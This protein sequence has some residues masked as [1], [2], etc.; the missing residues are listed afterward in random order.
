MRKIKIGEF[1]AVFN[2]M[3]E[4]FP[5]DEYRDKSAQRAL[6]DRSRYALY[7]EE[8]G[9]GAP[10]AFISVWRFD[11]FTYI[12]HFAVKAD[13]RSTG[14][15]GRMLTG[16]EQAERDAGRRLCLEVE[17]PCGDMQKRRIGFYE[18]NGFSLNFYPYEQP[19]FSENKKPVPLLIMSTCGTLTEEEFCSVR[20]LLY[21]EVYNKTAQN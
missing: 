8:D 3:K 14:I 7:V 16:L 1:D 18:R 20:A 9:N 19:A 13:M 17:P 12:E 21:K 2:I 15:G 4:S 5:R 11:G 10:G 6:L